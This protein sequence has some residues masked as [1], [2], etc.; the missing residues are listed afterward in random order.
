MHGKT[1]IAA[2]AL[3]R[4]PGADHGD[5]DNQ[6]VALVPRDRFRVNRIQPNL[7]TFEK[8]AL[9]AVHHDHPSAGHLGRDETLRQTRKY[10]Q[11]PGMK[12]WVA[13][14]VKG[15]STCQQNKT[16]TH[17][18]KNPLYRITTEPQALPLRQG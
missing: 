13:D 15:C 3:A 8:R 9:M 17:P 4:P 2:D 5:R 12:Q 1:N 11:W 7:S 6:N 14:Y 16:V 10:A 18:R